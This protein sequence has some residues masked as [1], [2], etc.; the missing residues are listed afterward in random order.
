[1]A[2]EKDN[3]QEKALLVAHAHSPA[4]ADPGPD[5]SFP[6]LLTNAREPR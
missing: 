6:C 2:H 4:C 1:M 5:P 3:G